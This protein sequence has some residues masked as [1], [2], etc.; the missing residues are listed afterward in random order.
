MK[1]I[2]YGVVIV[3]MGA[4]I[5]ITILTTTGVMNR[6]IE[7][8][9]S[10]QQAVEES[11]EKCVTTKKYTLSDNK[12]F[13]ADLIRELT[14]AVENDSELTV[15][16]MKV[17]KDKGYLAINVT[18]TY[19]TPLQQ[20]KTASY[21]TV[22]YLEKST[23]SDERDTITATFLRDN[24]EVIEKRIVITGEDIKPVDASKAGITYSGWRNTNTNHV[25][26]KN[27]TTLGTA[28]EEDL[29]FVAV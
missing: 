29:T 23:T 13:V 5:L 10:L 25:F 19:K 4:V 8:E 21:Q 1:N 27:S 7:I 14:N 20:D 17:D 22:A 16:I 6:R 12:L 28:G 2:I 3:L 26:D 9:N 15:D 18:E 24:G 11:I